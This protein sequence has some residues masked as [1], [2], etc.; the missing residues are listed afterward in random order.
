MPDKVAEVAELTPQ[1]KR[2]MTALKWLFRAGVLSFVALGCLIF[3]F[4][5]K[6]PRRP[7][8]GSGHVQPY[9]DKVHSN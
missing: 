8:A 9:F 4:G 5:E 3:Y 2:L 1:Q 7:D 6:G